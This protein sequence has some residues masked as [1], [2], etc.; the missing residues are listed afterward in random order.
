MLSSW[1]WPHFGHQGSQD[2]AGRHYD[3]A[4]DDE[5]CVQDFSSPALGSL[6][7]LPQ[8]VADGVGKMGLGKSG[9]NVGK[10]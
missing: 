10:T 8:M 1:S 7:T 5:A 4:D 6:H 9:K 3:D 2:R